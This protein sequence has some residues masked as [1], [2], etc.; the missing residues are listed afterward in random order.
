[1][2]PLLH[3]TLL[4]V[5]QVGTINPSGQELLGPAAPAPVEVFHVHL[6]KGR[7]FGLLVLDLMPDTPCCGIDKER[8]S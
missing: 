8:A 2:K 6:D 7:A 3:G 5:C 4:F 1:M